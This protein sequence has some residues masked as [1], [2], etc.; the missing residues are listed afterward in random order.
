MKRLFTTLCLVL[1]SCALS[2]PSL[3][4]QFQPAVYY[5]VARNA[6]LWGSVAADFNNDGNLDIAI[7]D[8]YNSRVDIMFGNGDGTF[9]AGTRFSSLAAIGLAPGDVNSDGNADLVVTR[10]LDPGKISIYF[11]NG[12]GTFHLSATATNGR[13]PIGVAIADLNGDGH[14]DFA[15]AN[16]NT[17]GKAGNVMVF[18]NN[19]DGS[20]ASPVRYA[21]SGHPWSIT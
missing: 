9:Q 2:T 20:F 10:Y 8:N 16:S 18:L 6:N 21:T 12:D 3:A 15:V 19:G 5:D 4:Q 7:A 13:Q 1:T 17:N 11:G 14:A